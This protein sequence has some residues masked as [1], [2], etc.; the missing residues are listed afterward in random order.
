V[1][2]R[3]LYVKYIEWVT[4]FIMFR[5]VLCTIIMTVFVLQHE[6]KLQIISRVLVSGKVNGIIQWLVYIIWGF[7][8]TPIIYVRSLWF[9]PPESSCSGRDS[10]NDGDY[11]TFTLHINTVRWMLLLSQTRGWGDWLLNSLIAGSRSQRQC[12]LELECKPGS[13]PQERELFRHYPELHL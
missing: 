12:L 4:L 6:I 2:P 8:M 5:I 10:N 7:Q 11:L 1:L 9:V 3:L 13:L